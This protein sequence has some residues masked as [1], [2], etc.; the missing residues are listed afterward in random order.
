M[1]EQV[2]YRLGRGIVGAYARSMYDMDVVHHVS[3]LKGPKIIAVNHPSTSDPFVT[4]LLTPE[5]VSVIVD[6]ALFEVPLFGHYLRGAGH[7]PALRGNGQVTLGAAQR[8]LEA[9]R[10][11]VI[12]PEGHVS[13]LEGGFY[14]PCTGTARLALRAG[15]PVIP[16]GIYIPR[17]RIRTL[18][19]KFAHKSGVTKWYPRGPYA[20][21]V[22]APMRLKGDI[23]DRPHVRAL[24]ERIMQRIIALSYESARRVEATPALAT[25][26]V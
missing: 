8:L 16:V 13:P 7:V 23:A 21:T 24:S 15:A 6:G 19:L 17:A 9:G 1:L 10:S 22:G 18:D 2:L 11:V 12:F 25:G 14:P 5:Q 3:L 26:S 20:M 4:T